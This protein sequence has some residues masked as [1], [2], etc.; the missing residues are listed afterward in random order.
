MYFLKKYYFLEEIILEREKKSL[1]RIFCTFCGAEIADRE[2]YWYINGACI[3]QLC[4]PE[5]ARQEYH[6]HR[7]VRGREGCY[8]AD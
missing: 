7:C 5:F 8:E 1:P 2:L 6:M 4:L 3:C